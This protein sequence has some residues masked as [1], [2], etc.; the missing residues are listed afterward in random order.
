MWKAVGVT[1]SRYL[2]IIVQIEML[3][4]SKHSVLPTAFDTGE[5]ERHRIL[6]D[7]VSQGTT[8]ENL[9]GRC[10]K[11]DLLRGGNR[12]HGIQSNLLSVA[13]IRRLETEVGD[14]EVDTRKCGFLTAPGRSCNIRS[15]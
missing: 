2:R 4:H 9:T 12:Q 11:T 10:R 15:G 3:I 6:M 8:E 5:I 1:G 13:T 7:K 14:T